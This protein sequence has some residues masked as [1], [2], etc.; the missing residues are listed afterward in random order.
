MRKLFNAFAQRKGVSADCLR[1]LLDG[2]C[3]DGNRT[4]RL[5]HLGDQE[6]IHCAMVVRK[7]IWSP[8]QIAA[9]DG[10]LGTC[11]TLIAKGVDLEQTERLEF[12]ERDSGSD[13]DQE[14][15]CDLNLFQ[16][17]NVTAL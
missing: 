10:E 13:D 17:Q 8:L 16:G 1:F 14:I 7:T 5:L 15:R 11:R 4:P 6:R 12:G 2:A 9:V 3:I